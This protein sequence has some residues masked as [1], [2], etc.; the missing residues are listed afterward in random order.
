MPIS[1]V[2]GLCLLLRQSP[3]RAFEADL[4]SVLKHVPFT[5]KQLPEIVARVALK[6]QKS[7]SKEERKI[8][9]KA[10]LGPT[11][12]KIGLVELRQDN[13]TDERN[14]FDLANLGFWRTDTGTGVQFLDGFTDI[15]EKYASFL[16]GTGYRIRDRLIRCGA[17]TREGNRSWP[18]ARIY[19][20]RNGRWRVVANKEINWPFGH[21]EFKKTNGQV[22]TTTI[23]SFTRNEPVNIPSPMSGPFLTYSQN[24]HI[25]ND[26][27]VTGRI[28]VVQNP[29]A[30]LDQ[31]IGFAR[32]G[33]RKAFNA[34]V[35]SS[36][37]AEL[38]SVL[39]TRFSV[40]CVGDK[41]EFDCDTFEL[42]SF[43]DK[44]K[45]HVTF[46]KRSGRWVAVKI[47]TD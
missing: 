20:L 40:H 14:T 18:G 11:P 1:C 4:K 17:A 35:P 16:E 45:G 19:R 37:R 38:W 24:W 39:R 12:M 26:K 42:E 41:T 7:V 30:E 25:H 29:V 23:I 10:C 6:Y 2:F 3:V 36:I 31:L 28:H 43:D 15:D 13:Y 9:W 47:V 33:H 34:R 32:G 21:A 27:F 22:S 44:L 8:H 5:S 46:A